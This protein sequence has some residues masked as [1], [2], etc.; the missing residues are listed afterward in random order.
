MKKFLLL[1]LVPVVLYCNGKPKIQ[2]DTL[3]HDF[4]KQQKN[5]ELKYTFVFKNLGEGSLRIDKIQPS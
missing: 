3:T 4:G 2:F 1:L 5:A